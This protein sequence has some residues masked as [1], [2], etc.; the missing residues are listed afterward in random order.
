MSSTAIFTKKKDD[1]DAASL[2]SSISTL[3]EVLPH[4]VNSGSSVSMTIFSSGFFCCHFFVFHDIFNCRNRFVSNFFHIPVF[5]FHFFDVFFC[6][7]IWLRG[8]VCVCMIEIV[9]R[10]WFFYQK[11]YVFFSFCCSI[12][13]VRLS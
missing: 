7:L 3:D 12:D 10:V 2:L 11:F 9:W 4:S 13:A 8:R 6:V 5:V 1:I